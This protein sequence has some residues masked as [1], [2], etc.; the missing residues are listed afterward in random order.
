MNGLKLEPGCRQAC[1]TWLNL[2]LPKSNPPTKARTAPSRGSKATN[3]PSTSGSWVTSHMFLAVFATR[4]KAPRLILTFGPALPAKPD[5]AG[6]K[7]SP[8]I[9]RVS[10]FAR[11]AKIRLGFAS[12]TTADITSPLSG[13]SDSASSTASSTSREFV[14][15]STN[16]SGPR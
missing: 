3:A 8:V 2:F 9:S 7:P 4:I 11:I 1:V 15:M 5:C 6:F 13:L 10:P 12:K 14:G 16:L